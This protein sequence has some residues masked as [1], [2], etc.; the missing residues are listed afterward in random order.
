MI[1]KLKVI[2]IMRKGIAA[3]LSPYAA[4]FLFASTQ[5]DTSVQEHWLYGSI[6]AVVL[7][8]LIVNI[9][10][11]N[12]KIMFPLNIL[13]TL[14]IILTLIYLA[15]YESACRDTLTC[16]LLLTIIPILT[17]IEHHKHRQI[18]QP[19]LTT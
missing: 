6:M 13:A 14:A 16:L 7:V 15:M 18:N 8:W 10:V 19:H 3:I 9:A 5:A 11:T 12:I 2:Q 17:S 4:L 1:M